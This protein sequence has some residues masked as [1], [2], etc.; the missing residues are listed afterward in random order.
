MCCIYYKKKKKN[1][2]NFEDKVYDF[3]L[4]ELISQILN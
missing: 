1:I 4:M 3:N 2:K